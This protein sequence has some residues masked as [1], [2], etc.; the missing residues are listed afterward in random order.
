MY[1][2]EKLKK[3]AGSFLLRSLLCVLVFF[4]ASLFWRYAPKEWGYVKKLL[5]ANSNLNL[6][7]SSL[8]KL[9]NELLPL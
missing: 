8:L 4:A 1:V 6:V 3:A 2:K 9:F 5:G 7:A